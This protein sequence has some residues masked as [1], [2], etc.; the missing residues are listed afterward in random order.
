[1]VLAAGQGTRMRSSLPK[2]LHAVAGRPM[3][4]NVIEAA[5]GAGSDTLAVVVGHGA[6][7]VREYLASTGTDAR[8]YVQETQEGT[9]HAV[10]A[11]RE[12]LEGGHDDVLVL[13]GDAP[14]LT[15]ATLRATRDRLSEDGAAVVVVGF[16]TPPP[17][18]YGRLIERD[19]EL[20]AIR[21]VK[22]ASEDER[23]IELCNGGFMALAGE[24]AL[25]LLD[26]IGNDNAKGEYYLTD[27]VEVARARGLRSVVHVADADE[28]LG[29]NDRAELAEAEAIWQ[30]RRRG[31]MLRAGVTMPDPASVHLAFDTRI[32]PDAVVEP[33]VFFGPGAAVEAGATVLSHSRIE[34][35]TVRSGATVGPFARLRPGT[36][37][38]AKA[39]VGNFCE[40]KNAELGE[41][42][43][44]NHLSYVGDAAVGDGA[45]VGAGTIT[46]NY[47]GVNKHR[48]EIGAGSFVGSNTSLV[49]PVSVGEGAYVASGS[50]VTQDV[51]ADALAFGRARQSVR[52]G[53]A[54][55]LRERAETLK[56][57]GR[58]ECDG[59]DGR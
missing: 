45:N 3:L 20:V 12:A 2:V 56:S 38:G 49:A 9:A 6:D 28:V 35:A 36:I 16:R 53:Y 29:V 21:E 31:E 19:G 59:G 10:L 22:D 42:A 47:D 1:M 30:R 11:A 46:C 41:G 26:A 27:V 37:V 13:F 50:V 33:F 5:R 24:H 25:A 52:E 39:K 23:R 51:P 54:P 34:G 48:T 43:K 58:A 8:S 32:E 57:A 55:V 4:G 40:V 7:R 17:N 15:A 18:G 44:V 14:M